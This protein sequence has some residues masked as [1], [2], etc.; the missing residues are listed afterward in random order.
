M[1]GFFSRRSRPIKSTENYFAQIWNQRIQAL[2]LQRLYMYV[3]NRKKSFRGIKDKVIMLLQNAT[4]GK[5]KEPQSYKWYG[6]KTSTSDDFLHESQSL[7]P[8]SAKYVCGLFDRQRSFIV[9]LLAANLSTSA[10][11][12]PAT[13]VLIQQNQHGDYKQNDIWQALQKRCTRR[14]RSR[15]G[16]FLLV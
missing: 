13:S 6:L 7:S 9:R 4:L 8:K 3:Y 12:L 16:I 14:R 10:N 11:Q 5:H 2:S 15:N 1:L